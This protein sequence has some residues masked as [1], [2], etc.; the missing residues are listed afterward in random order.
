[1]PSSMTGFALG[2]W[3]YRETGSATGFALTL[4]FNMLPKAVLAPLAGVLADRYERRT[5]MIMTDLFAG[6]ATII[7]DEK[8]W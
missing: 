2:V 6:I 5:I 8:L 7:T 1:M 4:L 3:V